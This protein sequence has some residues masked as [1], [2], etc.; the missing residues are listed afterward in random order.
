MVSY[1]LVST[2]CCSNASVIGAGSVSFVASI[3]VNVGTLLFLLLILFV[4]LTCVF[5]AV[6]DLSKQYFPSAC[7]N[8]GIL[9]AYTTGLIKELE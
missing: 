2:T 9:N 8:S 5:I 3:D 4:L 1:N 7:L 6:L